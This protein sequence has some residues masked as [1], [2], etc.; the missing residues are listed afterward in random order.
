MKDTHMMSVAAFLLLLVSGKMPV[1]GFL[2]VQKNTIKSSPSHSTSTPSPECFICQ[3]PCRASPR[4]NDDGRGTRTRVFL[5]D[6]AS[7]ESQ[8]IC[9]ETLNLSSSQYEQLM[10]L[11]EL[12]VE[13]NEKINIIS[14]KDC[15]VNTVWE[16]HIL[17]SI[18]CCAWTDGNPLHSSKTCVD[19][20]TGGGFPGLPLAIAFPDTQFLLLDSVGKKLTVVA[21][22]A[23]QLQLS[24]VKVHH[25]RAEELTGQKFDVATGRAVSSLD[26]LCTW[27]QHLLQPKTGRLLYW[28]GG[29][30]E[31]S[32][33]ERTTSDISIASAWIP[34]LAET[35]DKRVLQFPQVEVSEIARKSGI[36]LPKR[37]SIGQQQKK[38]KK[39]A[40]PD[41]STDKK[42]NA[43]GAWKKRSDEPKERGYEGFQR[44]DSSTRTSAQQKG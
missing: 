27:M 7:E 22:M 33:L 39:K 24:N 11:S 14:R 4:F 40:A 32:I 30:I 19:V 36:V 41:Q 42:K 35:C 29:D 34:A 6:P 9:L 23:E 15:T 13:W 3:P 8:E 18:A 31:S 16:R 28:I 26:Q 12:V 44:Y 20:G 2:V 38:K 5:M 37:L 10:R 25:G 21:D 17:P 1:Q 43:K